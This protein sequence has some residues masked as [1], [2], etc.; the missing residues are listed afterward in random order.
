MST[1]NNRDTSLKHSSLRTTPSTC[2]DCDSTL[3]TTDAETYCPDCGYLPDTPWPDHETATSGTAAAHSL[4]SQQPG[5]ACTERFH[6]RG[7]GSAIGS[8][9]SDKSSTSISDRARKRH[10]EAQLT[11]RKSRA[12]ADGLAEVRRLCTAISGGDSLADRAHRIFRTSHDAELA[13]GFSITQLAAASVIAALRDREQPIPI[14]AVLE[15]TDADARQVHLLLQHVYRETTAS[16]MPIDPVEHLPRLCVAVDAPRLVER[17][18]Y[19]ITVAA[20]DASLHAGTTPGSTPAAAIYIAVELTGA[21]ITQATIADAANV[22]RRT[23]HNRYTDLLD[24]GAVADAIA[25]AADD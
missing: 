1:N 7:L 11:T 3:V 6:D 25:A 15:D 9:S 2:P 21:E 23:I 12:K 5:A 19:R 4:N 24:A 17:V 14:T 10:A 22:T 8:D 18:A 20:R 16:P 13:I